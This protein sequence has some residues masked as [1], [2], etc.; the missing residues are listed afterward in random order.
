[1]ERER[2]GGRRGRD[3]DGDGAD[4]EVRRGGREG[5]GREMVACWYITQEGER[6]RESRQATLLCVRLRRAVLNERERERAALGSTLPLVLLR[7]RLN[8]TSSSPF[9]PPGSLA[10]SS[11]GTAAAISLVFSFPPLPPLSFS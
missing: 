5:R 9:G 10:L 8:H 1:M 4:R 11:L 7:L 6:E 3:G 2:G